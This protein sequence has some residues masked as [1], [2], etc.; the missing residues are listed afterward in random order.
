MSPAH[1]LLLKFKQ[2][3]CLLKEAAIILLAAWLAILAGEIIYRGAENTFDWLKTTLTPSI[4]SACYLSLFIAGTRLLLSLPAAIG[5]GVLA[6]LLYSLANHIKFEKLGSSINSSDFLLSGQYR[7]VVEIL[8]GTGTF[9]AFLVLIMACGW[10]LWLARRHLFRKSFSPTAGMAVHAICAASF[11]MLATLPD[12][13]FKNAR[14]RG[15]AVATGLDH[16]GISNFNW[17]PEANTRA[18]GQLLSLLM[19]ASTAFILP[20]AEYNEDAI[21]RV[22]SS[23][24]SAPASPSGRPDIIVIMNEAWWDPT[25][26]PGVGFSNALLSELESE[27]RSN[28]FS[29]IFGGYTANTE[30]EFITRLS[31]ANLPVGSIPYAQYVNRPIPT[32]VSDFNALGYETIAIHPYSS[33]FWNRDK[34]YPRFGFSRFESTDNASFEGA[35]SGFVK[36]TVLSRFIADELDK[37]DTPKFIFAVSMQNHGPYLDGSHRYA[38]KPRINIETKGRLNPEAV[39]LL[40]T[41]ATGVRDAVTGFNQLVRHIRNSGRPTLLVMFGDHLPF[42]GDDFLVYHQSGFISSQ[43]PTHWTP[44]DKRKMHTLPVVAWTNGAP[45]LLPQE[46]F[47]PIYLG[48]WIKRSVGLPLNS[49]DRL[50]LELQISHPIVARPGDYTGTESSDDLMQQYRAV[51]YDILFGENFAYPLLRPDATSASR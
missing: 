31:N 16:L 5:S 42:L 1:P 47:S 13:N 19:N 34:A 17:D 12:Y 48:T 11:L 39:D 38:D 35:S 49:M 45:A 10:L 32:L 21:R 29:P 24:S 26:L 4:V 2:I 20:P 23:Q 40:S 8:W 14:F 51:Q 6:F 44:E 30:F 27:S 46:Q 33:H 22:L 9:W 37:G 36:D 25:L 3:L 41:Y 7:G 28:L 18:N 50:L 15:S 43:D